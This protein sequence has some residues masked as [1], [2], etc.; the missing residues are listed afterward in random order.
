MIPV[1]DRPLL[2]LDYDGTL[3]EI[4]AN[5][6]EAWP[7]PGVLEL[8][9]ALSAHHPVFVVTGRR[10]RDLGALLPL[11][12][13]RAVGVHGME[14]GR[15]GE[16]A[17]PLVGQA[18]VAA[19]AEV[20]ETLPDYPGLTV[21]DKGVAVALHY[22]RAV[23]EA[24][25][26][27]VLEPWAAGLPGELEALWGKKVLELRP[28]GYGKG[29]AVARLAGEHPG[30]TPV[31]IGDDT[32][33]EEAFAVLA[34]GITVKVGPGETGARYRLDTIGEAVAYLRRYLV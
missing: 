34:E 8:L 10:L 18:E 4:V 25:V 12:G 29:R 31:F 22:R 32:T 15:L 6:M 3:A 26:R 17:R 5:P 28:K 23:D 9:T 13:L 20:R 2:L 33:D 27:S 7:Y 11:P 14:E 1:A 30:H 21:E 19:L 24:A 16:A